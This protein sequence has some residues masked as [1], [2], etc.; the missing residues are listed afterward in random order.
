M[1][2]S[3]CPAAGF[4]WSRESLTEL[5]IVA[6]LLGLGWGVEH[7]PYLVARPFLE[8]DPALSAPLIPGTVSTGA[9]FV[10]CTVV[11]GV[12]ILAAGLLRARVSGTW[13]WR[14][15]EGVWWAWM[16]LAFALALS[17]VAYGISKQVVGQV[18]AC[19][20]PC[21]ACAN[22]MHG[23]EGAG[24]CAGVCTGRVA[25]HGLRSQGR[26]SAFAMCNYA[27]YADALETKNFSAYLSA[28]D[29][30]RFGDWV[31]CRGPPDSVENAQQTFFSGHAALSFAGMLYLAFFLRR[32]ARVPAWDAASPMSLATTGA[33]LVLATCA[34]L[35]RA[36]ARWLMRTGCS[37]AHIRM[38]ALHI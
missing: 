22:T 18:R 37:R 11:P 29:P 33:P 9:L 28:T 3:S 13:R 7:G 24:C 17:V 32:V 26:P 16:G 1:R 23:T 25:A 4:L 5:A 10:I 2:C 14:V 34:A 19:A 6:S 27:G 15:A 31:R 38:F 8:R 35:A 30:S 36:R 21:I 20:V 12:L